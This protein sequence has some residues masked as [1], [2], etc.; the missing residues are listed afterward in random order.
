MSESLNYP[1]VSVIII[2]FKD[3]PIFNTVL[4]SLLNL[5]EYPNF[6]VTIIDYGSKQLKGMVDKLRA[7][8][9]KPLTL[10]MVEKD[11][12]KTHR[13][14][15]GFREGLLGNAKYFVLLDDDILIKGS[16]WLTKLVYLM[17]E[18]PN[19]VVVAQPGG[20][21]MLYPNGTVYA[22][23][24]WEKPK[25]MKAWTS[26]CGGG[27]YFIVRRSFIEEFYKCGLKPYCEMFYMQSED[28]DFAVKVYLRGYQA[29][30]VRGIE[31][32]HVGE[33]IAGIHRVFEAYKNRVML[34]LF[35][36]S[37]FHILKYM[38]FRILQDFIHATIVYPLRVESPTARG[39]IELIKAYYWVL[40]RLSP[41]MTTRSLIQ[42]RW[43]RIN[44]KDFD[45]WFL[46]VPLPL[47]IYDK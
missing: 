5:T 25:N 40:R 46:K 30:S 28:I 9:K 41:I 17:E 31:L 1:K 36:F 7:N 29:V 35:N 47:T 38:P 6:D 14:N 32:L 39:L 37:P 42:N 33:S 4:K 2:S 22:L 44:S 15:I 21:I 13:I 3:R 18:L 10:I 23:R 11:F 16:K 19:T 20:G 26:L 45:R 8:Y 27:G 43:L 12:G 34:L 24:D